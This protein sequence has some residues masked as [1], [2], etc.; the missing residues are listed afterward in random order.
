M[1][2]VPAPACRAALKEATDRWPGRATAS[3]GICSS[4]DHRRRSPG[5]DHD[6]GNAV[7]ITHNPGSGADCHVMAE[8][9]VARKDRRV[10]YLIWNQRIVRSYPKP[11]I[12]AWTWAPYTGTN[13]HTKHL[14]IS[15]R[16]ESRNDVAPWFAPIATAPEDD[17]F[18]DQDRDRLARV[19]AL[20]KGMNHVLVDA[21]GHTS[22][23]TKTLQA[24]RLAASLAGKQVDVEAVAASLADGLGTD[25]A[26]QVADELNRRLAG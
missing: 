2:C 12:P 24:A 11:D 7:D 26:K 23:L 21:D 25:V 4:A 10:K 1:G 9:I 8:R 17:M 5:S 18:S 22:N 20:A 15:I 3:D 6:V 13:P 14:H 19:E 16:Q